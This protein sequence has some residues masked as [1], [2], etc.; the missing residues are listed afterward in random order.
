MLQIEEEKI[1]IKR[2]SAALGENS[3]DNK[4]QWGA[5]SQGECGGR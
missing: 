1:H 3:G 5:E 4:V 2:P